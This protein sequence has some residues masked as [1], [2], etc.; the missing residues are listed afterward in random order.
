MTSHFTVKI[1]HTG[2]Y[3]YNIFDFIDIMINICKNRIIN[4]MVYKLYGLTET[5]ISIIENGI[6]YKLIESIYEQ[7]KINNSTRN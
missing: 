1:L 7:V 4:H 6:N 2:H 5:E 3:K